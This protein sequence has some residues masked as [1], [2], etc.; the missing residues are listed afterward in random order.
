M[1]KTNNYA[2]GQ[3]QGEGTRIWPDGS[4][5]KGNFK[6]SK[7]NGF[8]VWRKGMVETA[9]IYEG[10]FLDEKKHGK[11]KFT[12]GATGNVYEGDF[13][14]DQRQ[15]FGVY[16]W[17]DGTKYEGEW[18]DDMQHGTGKMIFPE[19]DKQIGEYVKGKF[20]DKLYKPIDN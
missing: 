19:G 13:Y 10:E 14:F 12:W 16:T 2:S 8:G 5:Y 18:L 17:L 3:L 20:Q 6:D 4:I 11:G 1:N 9:N 15:G 7:I